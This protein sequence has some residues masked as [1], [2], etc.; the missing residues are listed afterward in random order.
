M[1]KFIIKKK[2]HWLESCKSVSGDGK[3]V[4]IKELYNTEKT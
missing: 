3:A 2:K 4:N 1:V